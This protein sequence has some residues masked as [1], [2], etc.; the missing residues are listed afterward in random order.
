MH[1]L[2]QALTV[3]RRVWLDLNENIALCCYDDCI[4]TIRR[5][6]ATSSVRVLG[7]TCTFLFYVGKMAEHKQQK[8]AHVFV[9]GFQPL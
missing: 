9:K 2:L 6:S 1:R 7:K 3:V 4:H 8:S 5:A